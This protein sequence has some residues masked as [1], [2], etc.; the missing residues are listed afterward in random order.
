M[1][2]VPNKSEH[3]RVGE[4]GNMSQFGPEFRVGIFALLG[5]AATIFSVTVVSPEM[6]DTEGRV[7]YHTVL[8]DASGILPK[9]QVKTNGVNV[10]TV[11]GIE[12]DNNA[13]KVWLEV[14]D[15]VKIPVGSK[16]EVRTVGF[17]GDKFIEIK[18]TD[19]V[20][21]GLIDEKGLIPRDDEATDLNEVIAVVGSIAKDVKKVT[22]NLA[23]VLGDEKGQQSIQAIV[24]NIEDVT[25]EAK[26]ILEENR[27]DVRSIVDNIRT[28]SYSLNEVLND[29][30]KDRLDRILA[31]FDTSM[32]DVKGATKNINLISEKIEKG[33]GTIGRLV[34][35]DEAIEELEGAIKDIRKVLAPVNNLKVEVDYHGEYR[36]DE[37]TQNYFNLNFHTRPGSYYVLGFTDAGEAVLQSTTKTTT[38]ADGNPEEYKTFKEKD[39]IRFNVQ[40]AKRWHNVGVRFGLFESTGGIAGDLYGGADKYRLTFEVFE[41]ADADDDVRSFAHLKAYA[42]ALFYNH[43]YALAGIDDPTRKDTAGR[44]D[45]KVNYFVGAGVKFNDDDL[46][47]LFGLAAVASP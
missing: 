44:T 17:L 46:R 31:N 3:S 15:D 41:F 19:D 42:S 2:G 4:K 28:F 12:L 5:L 35:D 9:T 27:G 29:A 25:R 23:N 11:Q 18:R 16:I 39:E 20:S 14:R 13:T 40:I 7:V 22:E 21:K 43:I 36:R 38:D 26:A 37:S 1:H 33:E 34:N 30:N 8:K 24:D 47:A 32:V 10:G 6:F 45:T